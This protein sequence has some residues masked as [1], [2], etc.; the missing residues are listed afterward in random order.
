MHGLR[1]DASELNF[2]APEKAERIG[3]ISWQSAAVLSH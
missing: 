1:R 3:F 2:E